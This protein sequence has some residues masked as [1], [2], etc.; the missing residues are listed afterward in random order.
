MLLVFDLDDTIY[1]EETFVDSGFW[2]VAQFG[3]DR[4]GWNSEKSFLYMK[5]MLER[6]GRGQVFDRWLAENGQATRALVKKCVTIYHHHKPSIRLTEDTERLLFWLSRLH[7][8]YVVTDGHKIVQKYKIEALGI[9]KY[10]R[11]VMITHQYG[12]HHAKPS[13]YCFELI[14]RR[15][16]CN[17]E[18]M[19]YIGDNPYKDFVNL[20]PLG[21]LTVR[22]HTGAYRKVSVDSAYD[23]KYSIKSL[24]DLTQVLPLSE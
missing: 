12:K 14:R 10:F 22:V 9:K 18:E 4:F 20:N 1:D 6:E 7:P 23:A 8:L 2:A 5:R 3:E 21:V 17:W 24:A 16:G 11:K 15:E 13:T 19:A